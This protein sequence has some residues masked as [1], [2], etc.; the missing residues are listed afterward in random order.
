MGETDWR[1]RVE[2]VYSKVR[3]HKF[4]SVVF[5]EWLDSVLEASSNLNDFMVSLETSQD[6]YYEVT[7]KQ[8]PGLTGRLDAEI[9]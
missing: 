3:L 1:L 6:T 7:K 4:S 2:W 9:Y 8:I 5:R